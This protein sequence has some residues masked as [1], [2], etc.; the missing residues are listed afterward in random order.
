MWYCMNAKVIKDL[1]YKW[2]MK[3]LLKLHEPYGEYNLKEFSNITSSVS[4]LFF[5]SQVT[6]NFSS[7]H[8]LTNLLHNWE[9]RELA[10][11]NL[12]GSVN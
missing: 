4:P 12:H 10:R 11:I 3:I 1:R 8:M 7:F 2:Y 6:C 9:H 5:S